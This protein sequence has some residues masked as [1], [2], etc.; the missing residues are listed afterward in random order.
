MASVTVFVDDAVKGDFPPLCV[1]TGHPAASIATI[2]VPVGRPSGALWLLVLLG[3][4]GWLLLFILLAGRSSEEV[5][6][7]QLPY[8]KEIEDAFLGHRQQ[9]NLALVVGLV[10]GIL[11]ALPA[12]LLGNLL[13]FA[14]AGI[15]LIAAARRHW[16]MGH[17]DVVVRLDGSRR[18]VTIT[19]VADEFAQ[20]LESRGQRSIQ[21]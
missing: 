10:L 15:A 16:Q 18:W 21:N 1:R 17:N 9:R 12:L 4:V 14:P 11:L 8:S 6:T 5:L 7:V 3:P 13:W 20:A 2:R 19:G